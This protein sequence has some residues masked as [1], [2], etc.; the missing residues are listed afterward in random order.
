MELQNTVVSNDIANE[1]KNAK[2]MPQSCPPQ[3]AV[4]ADVSPVY[5]LIDGDIPVARDFLSHK[6][7]YPQ[8]RY[9][10]TQ[11]CKAT[12][13]SFFNS[14]EAA[15]DAKNSS[16]GLRSKKISEGKITK[17]CGTHELNNSTGH[18]SLWQFKDVD[19][20]KEFS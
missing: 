2:I 14:V 18:I 9:P 15:M 17:E 11:Q 6:E 13:L 4:C 16:K 8:K 7:L 1:Y 19:I 3:E 5:R 20:I 10:K 12:A